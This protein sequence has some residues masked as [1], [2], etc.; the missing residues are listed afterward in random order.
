[1]DRPL[2]AVVALVLIVSGLGAYFL[3]R[4]PK[5]PEIKLPNET[6]TVT[7][8][9]NTIIISDFAFNP[10]ILKV[11]A[12]ETVTWLN[13]DSATHTVKSS[14]MHSQNLQYNDV[15]QFQFTKP[16]T[17]SYTCGMHSYMK[18]EIIVE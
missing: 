16:G 6:T 10:E 9:K 2:V 7:I 14:L 17:Y 15:Y 12:G 18:G 3:L 5:K 13:K 4:S 8:G 11:K 1:M